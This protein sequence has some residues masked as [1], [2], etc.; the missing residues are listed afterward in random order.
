[1]GDYSNRAW[2]VHRGNVTW[3]GVLMRLSMRPPSKLLVLV[4]AGALASGFLLGACGGGSSDDG[5]SGVAPAGDDATTV[6]AGGDDAAAVPAGDDAESIV[7]HATELLDDAV[8]DTSADAR[9][10]VVLDGTTYEFRALPDPEDA[11][12][13]FC[14][15]VAGSLQ[16]YL[17]LVDE[18]GAAVDDAGLTFELFPPDSAYADGGI[19]EGIT[20]ELPPS[21]PNVIGPLTYMASGDAIDSE[22]SGRSAS[23]SFT[24]QHVSGDLSGTIDVSC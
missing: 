14:T 12:G 6:S 7:D 16:G 17:R 13:S 10:T 1:M 22:T 19:P 20:L 3:F 15:T 21:D 18:S 4:T 2:A 23:A 24:T 8:E 5:S 11:W 9:A